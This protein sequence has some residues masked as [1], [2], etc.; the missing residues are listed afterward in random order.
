MKV[1][2]EFP[3][4]VLGQRQS[5][6]IR[7]IAKLTAAHT[8]KG[9]RL[10]VTLRYGKEFFYDYDDFGGA[11]DEMTKVMDAIKTFNEL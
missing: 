5:I 6:A 11:S 3:M 2:Y 1:F 4:P 7:E 9:S 8:E 10:W